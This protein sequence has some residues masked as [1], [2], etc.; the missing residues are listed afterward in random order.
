MEGREVESLCIVNT[1]CPFP[2]HP[3]TIPTIPQNLMIVT[4]AFTHIIHLPKGIPKQDFGAVNLRCK[5]VK[6]GG[7]LRMDFGDV[8]RQPKSAEMLLGF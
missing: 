8:A 1:S 7:Y 2:P 6:E 4:F 5:F 3:H